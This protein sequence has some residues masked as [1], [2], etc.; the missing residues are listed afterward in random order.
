MRQLD[1]M[2]DKSDP[3]LQEKR[4]AELRSWL[5]YVFDTGDL[6]KDGEIDLTE[7]E[8]LQKLSDDK[9]LKEWDQ[10]KDI[11]AA[12]EYTDDEWEKFKKEH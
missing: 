8:Y 10:W 6:N 7:L 5:K 12:D 2:F 9:Q 1:E 3:S 4:V 11:V